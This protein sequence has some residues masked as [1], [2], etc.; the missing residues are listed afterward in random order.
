[1]ATHASGN[2]IRTTA[3]RALA[4]VLERNS[5][6][7]H[8]DVSCECRRD[9]GV[10]CRAMMRW[11]MMRCDCVREARVVCF[12]TCVATH[13]SGNKI[14]A[15]GA[16]ALASALERNRTLHHLNVGGEWRHDGCVA[17]SKCDVVVRCDVIV[18]ERIDWFVS[19]AVCA[20][21]HAPESSIGA[22][23]A[24]A[25]A[26]ALGANSTLQH[27]DA[28][29]ELSCGG[30]CVRNVVLWLLARCDWAQL[31]LVAVFRDVRCMH[32]AT[33][34]VR[35]ARRRLHR[36]WRGTAHC[37]ISMSTVRGIVMLE[38]VMF[39]VRYCG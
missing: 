12:V 1:M 18:C 36:R 2:Q 24:T 15:V 17:C 33:A 10:L 3:T 14:G 20:A 37:S 38:Y 30:V 5:T 16:T 7:Q 6:L 27:L 8:L 4:S 11:I 23:G 34:L 19:R 28:S 22:E 29:S 35:R 9:T 32:Q 39:G 21:T 13:A 31:N 25:L 26:S